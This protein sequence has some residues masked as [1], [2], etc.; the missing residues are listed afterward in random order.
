MESMVHES[1][2]VFVVSGGYF[3]NLYMTLMS[4]PMMTV[5]QTI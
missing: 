3:R 2:H 4:I 5:I 1:N